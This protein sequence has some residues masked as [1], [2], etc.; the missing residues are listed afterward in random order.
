MLVSL[1]RNG[2]SVAGGDYDMVAESIPR[3]AT[4]AT[5][6]ILESMMV[7]EGEKM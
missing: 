6:L 5:D 3:R 7:A 4:V 2:G 1:L